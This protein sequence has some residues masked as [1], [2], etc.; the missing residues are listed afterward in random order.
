MQSIKIT[1]EYTFEEIKDDF[2]Q[3]M[4]VACEELDTMSKD[5]NTIC[6]SLDLKVLNIANFSENVGAAR[7]NLF[8]IDQLLSQ[9]MMSVES[10]MQTADEQQVSEPEV[11]EDDQAG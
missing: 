10:I 11:Q 8:I 9:V 5:V 3:K 7:R 4:K 1:K 6:S 2:K